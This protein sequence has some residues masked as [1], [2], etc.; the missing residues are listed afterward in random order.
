MA[1]DCD[2]TERNL[3][4]LLHRSQGVLFSQP[5]LAEAIRKEDI[6]TLALQP[7][8]NLHRIASIKVN[9]KAQ[10]GFQDLFLD[11]ASDI[12]RY[13]EASPTMRLPVSEV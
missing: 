5:A 9:C 10:Q 13:L 8:N 4:Q 6:Q 3:K 2:R 12:A 11:A 7:R 1:P